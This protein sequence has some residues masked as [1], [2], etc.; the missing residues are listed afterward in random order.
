MFRSN[1][2][3][4]NAAK[5]RILLFGPSISNDKASYGG[6]RGGYTRKM[7]LYLQLCES[8]EFE[9]FPC[10]HSLRTSGWAHNSGFRMA[11]DLFVFVRAI[12]STRPSIVHV[13]GQYRGATPREFLVI[14]LAKALRLRIVYEMKGG[15][16]HT[17]YPKANYVYKKLIRCCL[18]RADAILCQGAPFVEFIDKEFARNGVYYPNVVHESEIPE[19]IDL[20]LQGAVIRVLFVGFAYD[21]KGIRELVEGCE[22]ASRLVPIALTIVG[23]EHPDVSR[24]MDKRPRYANLTIDRVGPQRHDIALGFYGRNDVYLYPTRHAGEGHNN[25]IN[26][27]MMHGM[28]IAVSKMGFL[29]TVL[30]DDSAYFIDAV[31]AEEVARVILEIARDRKA[32]VAKGERA[33][34]RLLE[35]FV[36]RKAF[37]KLTAVYR[38]LRAPGTTPISDQREM[39]PE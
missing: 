34:A 35:H 17:W 31:R 1:Q 21:G 33:R 19:R 32:A 26:E 28:V 39:R 4:R 8:E 25:T 18:L 38:S 22:V 5:Q 27:A 36:A 14:A 6:G 37:D 24:W 3:T 11:Q 13:L 23:Q 7:E 20:K 12:W 30:S 16:F 10:F 2:L 29:E 15:V 9:F